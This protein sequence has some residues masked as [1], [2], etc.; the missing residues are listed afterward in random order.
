MS[1]RK[2]KRQCDQYLQSRR[3]QGHLELSTV[4]VPLDFCFGL[5]F[6]QAIREHSSDVDESYSGC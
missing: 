6:K 3:S 1:S 5:G 2:T 4:L